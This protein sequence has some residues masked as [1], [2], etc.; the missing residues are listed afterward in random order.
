MKMTSILTAAALLL[1]SVPLRTTRPAAPRALATRARQT[2]RATFVVHVTRPAIRVVV[3]TA[4]AC[5]C[6]RRTSMD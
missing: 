2:H 3:A 4:V 1:C 6:F 5:T